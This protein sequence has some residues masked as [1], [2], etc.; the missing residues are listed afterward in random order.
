[1]QYYWSNRAAILSCDHDSCVEDYPTDDADLMRAG[2]IIEGGRRFTI[3]NLPELRRNHE[4]SV[5]IILSTGL[6]L[7]WFGQVGEGNIF[8]S[9]RGFLG[10]NMPDIAF[11][12]SAGLIF[13]LPNTERFTGLISLTYER[14]LTHEESAETSRHGEDIEIYLPANSLT[15][16]LGTNFDI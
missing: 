3:R 2:G 9:N 8:I 4:S 6:R 16:G 10:I 14:L 7:G 1:M 5:N 11:R 12:A 13:R 15:I